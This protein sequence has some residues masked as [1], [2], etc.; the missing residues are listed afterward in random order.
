MTIGQP[1]AEKRPRF[2]GRRAF[3]AAAIALPFGSACAT[4]DLVARSIA[5]KAKPSVPELPTVRI[6]YPKLDYYYP[7]K[8]RLHTAA[9]DIPAERAFNVDIQPIS[10]AIPTGEN[11]SLDIPPPMAQMPRVYAERLRTSTFKSDLVVIDP[12]TIGGLAHADVLHDLGPLLARES[13]YASD[14]FVGGALGA[15]THGGKLLA[16]PIEVTVEMVWRNRVAWSARGI[17]A[18]PVDWRWEQFVD[19]ARR[20]T[21]GSGSRAW[22]CQITP[23]SPSLWAVAWQQGAE[24]VSPDGTRFTLTEPGTIRAAAF[25]S[26]LVNRYHVTPAFDGALPSP[27]V[28][29]LTRAY[30][31]DTARF[32]RQFPYGVATAGG[33]VGGPAWARP[34]D[35]QLTALPTDGKPTFLGVAFLMLGIPKHAPDLRQSLAALRAYVEVGGQTLLTPTRG[36]LSNLRTDAMGLSDVEANA[37]RT[38]VENARYMPADLPLDL[39]ATAQREFIVPVLQGTR[40]PDL[41]ARDARMSIEARLRH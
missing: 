30:G 9:K 22:G 39:I 41:A 36:A 34:I 17:E 40:P 15:G 3:L 26:D 37:L 27:E 4:I 2:L 35:G 38:T 5:M 24:V 23:T 13:W 21:G 18:P 28:H 7:L 11:D 10:L 14:A 19:A 6:A 32:G 16:V 1:I 12:A 31:L 25:L 8:T 29:P 33:F 20:L